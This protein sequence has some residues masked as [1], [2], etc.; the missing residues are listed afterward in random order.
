MNFDRIAPF[1]AALERL[2]VGNLQ[3][4]ARERFLPEVRSARR[5]LLVGEGDGRFLAAALTACPQAHFTVIEAS[6][7]ML[8]LA[9]RRSSAV[10]ER[11]T[12][13]DDRAGARPHPGTD[14]VAFVHAALPDWQPA[15]AGAFDLVVTNFFFDCFTPVELAPIVASLS[16]AAAPACTWLVAE[17]APARSWRSRAL[18]ALAYSFFRLTAGVRARS[19]PDHSGLMKAHGFRLLREESMSRGLITT[20]LWCRSAAES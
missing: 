7:C 17:F 18:L 13:T 1:Y 19:V 10:G 5:V 8:D 3:Q 2:T 16:D 20:Q 11:S 15:S 9:R 14:R 12:S 4:R 6:A